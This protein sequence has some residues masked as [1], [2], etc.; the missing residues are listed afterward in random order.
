MSGLSVGV[1]VIEAPEK[2]GSVGSIVLIAAVAVVVIGG[3][4]A[5]AL[6][7]KKK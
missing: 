2:S 6:H 4:V 7:R 1:T 3:A 5:Y